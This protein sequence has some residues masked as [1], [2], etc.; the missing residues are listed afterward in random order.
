[1]YFQDKALVWTAS[2]NDSGIDLCLFVGVK[3]NYIA[4]LHARQAHINV[5]T[6]GGNLAA[7]SCKKFQSR[8]TS[9]YG[10]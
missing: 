1:M 5:S 8:L 10:Q 3:C 2:V 9:S 6:W 7:Q 4:A